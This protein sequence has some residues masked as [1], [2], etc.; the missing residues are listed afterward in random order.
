MT[1]RDK[2]D[3]LIREKR[4][5]YQ[6]TTDDG[7][8]IYWVDGDSGRTRTVTLDADGSWTCDCPFM[9]GLCAH[10]TAVLDLHL[11]P[12][13]DAGRGTILSPDVPIEHI[14]TARADLG[15]DPIERPSSPDIDDDGPDDTFEIEVVGDDGPRNLDDPERRRALD[16]QTV[17]LATQP[18]TWAVLENIA[19]TEFVPASLRGKPMACLAAIFTGRELGIGPMTSLRQIAVIDGSPTLSAELMVKLY[20][21]SGHRLDVEQM[22]DTAVRLT[23]TRGDTGESMTVSFTIEDAHRAGLV[24]ISPDGVVSA[25]SQR[26][27]P[28]PW[29]TYTPDLLWA[30]A[31]TRLIRRLAPD[32]RGDETTAHD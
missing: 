26:G 32:L 14:P 8:L 10:A 3:R 23:G 21:Q 7:S 29:E 30:R 27:R 11:P 22:D 28:L 1:V 31:V 9:G 19:R 18:I 13:P 2:A 12:D 16:A 20:R 25:R 4:I 24:T 17:D 5:H 6:M 15:P